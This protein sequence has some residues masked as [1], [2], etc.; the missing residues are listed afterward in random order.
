MQVIADAPDPLTALLETTPTVRPLWNYLA[1]A[2]R[3][4]WCFLFTDQSY[5]GDGYSKRED[6]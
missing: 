3:S 4:A 6:L 2:G 5:G 1:I